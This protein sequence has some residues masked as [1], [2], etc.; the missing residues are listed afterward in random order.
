MPGSPPGDTPAEVISSDPIAAHR[1]LEQRITA[2]HPPTA[3]ELL[4]P[5]EQYRAAVLLAGPASAARLPDDIVAELWADHEALLRILAR[6]AALIAER[7]E[8]SPADADADD[9]SSGMRA[10]PPFAGETCRR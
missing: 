10:P 8:P 2:G 7:R 5:W 1:R 4:T 3:G 6:R 9:T